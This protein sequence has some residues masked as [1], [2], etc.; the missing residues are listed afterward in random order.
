MLPDAND[1]LEVDLI[2]TRPQS[3]HHLPTEPRAIRG[4]GKPLQ[5]VKRDFKPTMLKQIARVERAGSA[6]IKSELRAEPG[7]HIAQQPLPHLQLRDEDVQRLP[8]RLFLAAQEDHTD[9]GATRRCW[10]ANQSDSGDGETP[11]Y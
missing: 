7:Q 6:H 2:T 10:L 11:G 5:Q 9:A 1:E 4:R 8:L 3:L